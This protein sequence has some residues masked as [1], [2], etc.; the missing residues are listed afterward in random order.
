MKRA[1]IYKT[2]EATR[3]IFRLECLSLTKD[4]ARIPGHIKVK[5]IKDG[6]IL[7]RERAGKPDFRSH[8]VIQDVVTQ[9]G[10]D[11]IIKFEE[12]KDLE[13]SDR[14]TFAYSIDVE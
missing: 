7:R 12:A 2:V 13:T 9:K 10:E 5:S 4:E 8:V 14:P 6:M 3:C 11:S 1:Y